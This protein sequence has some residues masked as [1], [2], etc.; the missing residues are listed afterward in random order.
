MKK[1]K[2]Q[3]HCISYKISASNHSASTSVES[4]DLISS[5]QEV[6]Q[7]KNK[8]LEQ[9]LNWTPNLLRKPKPHKG[10]GITSM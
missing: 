8:S 1:S 6:Q 7:K 9:D 3:N 5:S 2:I 10:K 4:S